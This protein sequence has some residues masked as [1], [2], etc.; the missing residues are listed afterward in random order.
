MGSRVT[1]GSPEPLG[2]T[3]DA[4][5]ANV[6]VFSA[7]AT[8]IELCLFDAD[9]QTEI[10]R[11]RLPFRTGDVFH[12]HVAGVTRRASAMACAPTVPT[13]R[14]RGIASIRPSCSS[15]RTRWRS[16][17]PSPSPQHVRLR[18]AD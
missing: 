7:H 14:R 5:G 12:G 9:G 18:R 1:E 17:G 16:T 4:R 6:A 3:L 15:T 8:A 10:E 2:L 13:P 11:L